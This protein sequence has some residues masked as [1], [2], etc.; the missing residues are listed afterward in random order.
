MHKT[1]LVSI[2]FRGHLPEEIVKAAAKAG[3]GC[4]EWGSD[5]H[6]PCGDSE[7]LHQIAQLQ[8]EY[9]IACCS[10]GT[11]FRLGVTPLSELSKYIQAAKILGTDILRLWC[12]TKPAEAY[13]PEEK[14]ALFSQC[15]QAAAMAEATGVILCMECHIKSFT[16]TVAGALELMEA[17]NSPAFRMYWQP[18]QFRSIEENRHYAR[19][20]REYTTHIH[21]FQWKGKERFPLSD[22]IAE[23]KAYLSE[24]SGSH[25]LLL[26]FM[27]DD[28]IGSLPREADA[29]RELTGGSL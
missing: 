5:V 20:L 15:R 27:P 26:E 12:G 3:L 17:V 6:A 10:Y 28:D 19:A 13:E 8:A 1:G 9:G 11:Y 21:V 24:F 22:G 14:E 7:K 29:L 2:S 18:N 4:I 25:A 23:W 16:E